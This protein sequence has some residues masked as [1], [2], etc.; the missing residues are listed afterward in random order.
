MS[1]FEKKSYAL[2]S[3]AALLAMLSLTA[4]VARAPSSAKQ[5]AAKVERVANVEV[6][7]TLEDRKLA[8]PVKGVQPGAIRDNFEEGRGKRKHEAIDIFAPRGTPVVAVDDGRIAK[9]FTSVAGGLT[10]YQFDPSERFIY[11]YAH[12]DGYADELKEGIPVKRGEL[13]GYVGTSGNAPKATPH[14]HFTIF[15][16]TPDKKWWKGEAINPYPFLARAE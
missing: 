12:L 11:Y 5:A 10:V 3:L 7:Q 2:L 8:M 16:A 6:S 15:R 14:L 1:R 9:L 4:A 13:I